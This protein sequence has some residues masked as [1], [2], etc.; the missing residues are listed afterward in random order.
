[1]LLDG[2]PA[3]GASTASSA[4]HDPLRPDFFYHGAFAIGFVILSLHRD[5]RQDARRD[6]R[7]RSDGSLFFFFDF[8]LFTLHGQPR[9]E[10][11][12]VSCK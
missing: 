10:R 8:C 6:V 1:M 2:L 3:H 7:F 9:G 4:F 11:P 12:E 5:G